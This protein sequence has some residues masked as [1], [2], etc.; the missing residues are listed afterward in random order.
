[1]SLGCWWLDPR[2]F[3]GVG[4][5]VVQLGSFRVLRF[6]L[7]TTQNTK[8]ND[9]CRFVEDIFDGGQYV[10]HEYHGS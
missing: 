5:E 3:E 9:M 6:L 2:G 8:K 7:L 1:M 10:F 4:P